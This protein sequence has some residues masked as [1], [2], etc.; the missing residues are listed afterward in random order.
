M[1]F[2]RRVYLVSPVDGITP[3]LWIQ[4]STDPPDTL[5]GGIQAQWPAVVV[6]VDTPATYGVKVSDWITGLCRKMVAGGM[7]QVIVVTVTFSALVPLTLDNV[8]V[9][10]GECKTCGIDIARVGLAMGPL[11]LT[12]SGV[13]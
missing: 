7:T 12:Y 2:H 1:P 6:G 4:L 10:E 5:T 3:G 11:G 8:S 13:M 9:S